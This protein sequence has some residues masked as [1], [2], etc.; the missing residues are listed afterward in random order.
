MLYTTVQNGS[1]LN[2]LSDCLNAAVY[3]RDHAALDH[4]VTHQLGH[5]GHF[6]A[7]NDTVRVVDIQHQAAH[8]GQQDQLLCA[9]CDCQLAG[10]GVGVDI[11]VGF[12]VDALCNG[13]NDRDVSLLQH[14]DDR[15]RV[16]VMISPT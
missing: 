16:N 1:T 8:V 12:I 11:V 14:I 9:E 15:S 6:Q 4:A 3:L 10:C 2:A 13:R 5:F 7:V